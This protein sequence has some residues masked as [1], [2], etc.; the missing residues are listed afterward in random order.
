MNSHRR[1]RQS[2]TPHQQNTTHS[3][4]RS[5]PQDIRVNTQSDP[6]TYRH[7]QWPRHSEYR[8]L[9]SDYSPRHSSRS[10]RHS[11]HSPRHLPRNS[12]HAPRHTLASNSLY[13]AVDPFVIP[14]SNR[15]SVWHQLRRAVWHI[16]NKFAVKRD[17]KMRR[18]NMRKR[19]AGVERQ[20]NI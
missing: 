20:L 11:R 16:G 1:S 15:P 8:P 13:R 10:P 5:K 7:A 18:S 14:R 6:N 2:R 19:S 9:Y 17:P 3:P 4:E 12:D